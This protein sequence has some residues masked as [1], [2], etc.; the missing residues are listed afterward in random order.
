MDFY[1]LVN[2]P[3]ENDG[4]VEFDEGKAW[5]KNR[6]LH[7]EDGPAVELYDGAKMWFLN[8]ENHRT[9]GP[10]IIRSNGTTEWW[11]HNELTTEEEFNQW[12]A[13]K[14]LNDSLHQELETRT[15]KS[16]RKI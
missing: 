1:Y 11:I 2:N 15:E 10:A 3:P 8:G 6:D 9:D 13:K 5:F 12:Q 4:M 7:R 14:R 16:K